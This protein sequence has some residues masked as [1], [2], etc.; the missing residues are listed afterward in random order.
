MYCYFADIFAVHC[1]AHL[2]IYGYS[3]IFDPP[4]HS[5]IM[6]VTGQTIVVERIYWQGYANPGKFIL[7]K[8]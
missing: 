3:S 4:T 5:T 2:T 8:K 1:T 7:A 6:D